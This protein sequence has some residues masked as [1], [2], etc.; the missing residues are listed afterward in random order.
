MVLEQ[1]PL[2][3]LRFELETVERAQVPAYKGDLLR[4]ALLWWLSEYWCPLSRRCRQGCRRPAVCLFGR[5]CEPPVDPT[6]PAPMRRLMGNTPPPAYALWDRQDR[7]RELAVGAAWSFDLTL[8]GELAVRQVPAVVAAVQEG[9][10]AGMGRVRLRSRLVRVRALPGDGEGEEALCLAEQQGREGQAAGEEPMLTWR[11]FGLEEVRVGYQAAGQRAARLCKPVRSLSL[12]FLSPTKIKERGRWVSRPEFSPVIKAVV[13]RLRL[14]SQVHGAGEWPQA[15]WG[16]LLDLAETVRL[17]HEET[18][19]TRYV[20]RT[21]SS[22]KQQVEG[23]VGQSWYGGEDLRPLLPVLWLGEWL[24]I[25]KG[26]VWGQGK[27]VVA[28]VERAEVH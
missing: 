10:T 14:L 25:G 23:F 6:W 12:R 9:A 11:N 27:Y 3:R 26:Y 4:M 18:M 22:G 16:P 5:L 1:L 19:W 20:R 24:Q 28:G 2:A 17:E 13:R 15:E 7:R 21:R 8:V